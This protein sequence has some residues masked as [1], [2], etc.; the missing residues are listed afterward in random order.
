M[1]ELK[2]LIDCTITDIYESGNDIVIRSNPYDG[3]EFEIRV[4][5]NT[6]SFVRIRPKHCKLCGKFDELTTVNTIDCDICSDCNSLVKCRLCGDTSRAYTCYYDKNN[7]VDYC[8]NCYDAK[9]E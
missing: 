1:D 9:E 2:K 3:E 5:T 6:I 4:P 7:K 8:A